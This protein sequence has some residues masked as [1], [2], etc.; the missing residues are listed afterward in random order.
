MLQS[1]KVT[2]HCTGFNQSRFDQPLLSFFLYS[3]EQGKIASRRRP[4]KPLENAAA[5]L[6]GPSGV[7][8]STVGRPSSRKVGRPPIARKPTSL[9]SRGF[10]YFTPHTPVMQGHDGRHEDEW[11]VVARLGGWGVQRWC[12]GCIDQPHDSSMQEQG[13][14][15]SERARERESE[16]AIG[17][18][19]WAGGEH[20]MYMWGCKVLHQERDEAPS[21]GA[22]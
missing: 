4:P 22:L 5:V 3:F 10:Q 21:S 19:G 14:T 1:R 7:L 6:H 2:Q 8:L 13:E 9:P 12:C 15:E 11:F 16:R 18:G 20:R 17:G